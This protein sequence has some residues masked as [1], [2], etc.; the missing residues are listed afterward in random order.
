MGGTSR[1]V[2]NLIALGLRGPSPQMERSYVTNITRAAVL[3]VSFSLAGATAVQAQLPECRNLRYR[4]NFR[5]NSAQNYL[6]QAERQGIVPSD[7]QRRLTDALRNLNE[8]AAAGGVDELTLWYMFART[9][10]LQGDLNGADTAWTR[11]ST[12]ARRA[13][14]NDCVAELLRQRRNERVPLVN[15]A[16]EQMSAQHYDSALVLLRRAVRIYPDPATY[17]AI[18]TIF[19]NQDRLDS[20]A[21][22]F[23]VASR[24]GTDSAQAE[25]RSASAFNAAR[26][27]HA[28]SH[29]PE[30]EAAYRQ[31]L[32][33]RPADMA[34]RT[35]LAAVLTRQG[36]AD[37]AAAIY[38]SII[39]NAAALESF[40]LF[41]TGV[42]LFQQAQADSADRASRNRKLGLS[43]RA[44][45]LGLEKNPNFRNALFNLVNTYLLA[46]DT[47]RAADA[48]RR[49]MAVDPNHRNPI[50]LLAETYRRRAAAL[51][52]R[53]DA[54]AARRDS[55]AAARE[56]RA[57]YQALTDTTLA[58]IQRRDSLAIEVGVTT[59]EPRD[60]AATLRG[61]VQNLQGRE[62]RA[63]VLVFEFVNGRGEA[64]ATERVDLPALSATGAPGALYD[65]NLR[66]A[67]TGI[68]AYRYRFQN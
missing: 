19:Y 42:A 54:L 39:A 1:K 32:L 41:E 45:E 48:A 8:A 43:A 11:A 22:Y 66:V 28:G 65:F 62:Q 57:R 17:Q 40:D 15:G 14:D 26:I 46:D 9:Y 47:A 13:N 56:V 60:S 10:V 63:S 6:I 33:M 37:A 30:A 4:S 23:L 61:A 67:G 35:N 52:T 20:A 2:P 24:T 29:W 27:L 5:L 31:Y 51:R 59:F 34:A 64:V 36:R 16:G 58:L 68:I 12:I 53:Y 44:F 21:H 50:S 49:L 25:V 3:L 7:K 55:V 18:A 38:D